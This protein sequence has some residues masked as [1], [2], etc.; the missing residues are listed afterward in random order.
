MG[1]VHKNRLVLAK[2]FGVDV[3]LV[4]AILGIGW[5]FM[6][7]TI[8]VFLGLVALP[9]LVMANL[10]LSLPEDNRTVWHCMVAGFAVSVMT[11]LGQA[12]ALSYIFQ[13]DPFIAIFLLGGMAITLVLGTIGYRIYGAGIADC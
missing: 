7:Q 12:W 8:L 5:T 11:M 1:A 6:G 2:C 4:F 10:L 13:P 9:C 3:L